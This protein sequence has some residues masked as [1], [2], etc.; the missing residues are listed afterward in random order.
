MEQYNYASDNVNRKGYISKESILSLISQED[1]FKLVLNYTPKELEYVKSPLREDKTPGCWFSYH[2]TG[3]LYFID[4]GNTRT[5]SDCFNLVQDYFGLPNFYLTL[6]YINNSLIQGKALK[7]PAKLHLGDKKEVKTTR[8]K[9]LIEARPFSVPD[10]YFWS[11]LGITKAQLVEDRVFPVSRFYALNTKKGNIT[12]ACPDLAYSYNEFLDGKKK[13]YFPKRVG[14]RRFLTNCTKNDI[15]GIHSL[16]QYTK[17][18]IITKSYKDWRI[19]K[20]KG[21]NVIW[22]QNEGMLPDVDI[23]K[24]I[25]RPYTQIVVWFDNDEAGIKAATKVAA[26]INNL[27]P[28]RAKCL[29]LP[30]RLLSEGVTDPADCQL[31]DKTILHKFIQDFTYEN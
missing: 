24:E 1:I 29:S 4:F 15:G 3:V 14:K 6:E 17:Q 22:F 12:T 7:A 10:M 23:L 26:Y 28:N 21:K 18:L 11:P 2:I 30:E 8:V 9:I 20:N 13:L 16:S 19:L 5:H 25:L 27:Y 31:Y